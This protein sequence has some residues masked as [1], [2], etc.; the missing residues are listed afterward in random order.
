MSIDPTSTVLHWQGAPEPYVLGRTGRE[1]ERQIIQAS[2]WE[3]TT[4][5]ALQQV[6]LRA[7]HRAIDVGCGPCDV[8]RLMRE[9]VG[10][11]GEITGMDIDAQLAEFALPGLR[12]FGASNFHF[13]EHDVTCNDA[14]AARLDRQL[15]GSQDLVFARLLLFHLRDQQAA[16]SRLWQWVR[17]GGVLLVMDYDTTVVRCDPQIPAI[18]RALRIA[19]DTF[20]RAGRDLETGTRMLSLFASGAP[21][22]PDGAAVSSVIRP[23]QPSTHML[24]ELLWS[25]RPQI[26]RHRIA[27]LDVLRSLDSQLHA[28]AAATA[29]MRWPDMVATWK[30]KSV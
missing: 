6:G 3:Q 20:R 19:N 29:F 2:V 17:P 26:L 14:A 9:F 7:G 22:V 24:R 30:R 8:M 1:Y 23:A 5:Q 10:A 28:A 27:T 12:Q 18:E 25:L 15:A 4:R 16:L 11:E 21:G 13:I